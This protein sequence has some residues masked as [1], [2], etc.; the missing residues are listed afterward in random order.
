VEVAQLRA[1]LAEAAVRAQRETER[2]YDAGHSAG[3]RA[4][5]ERLEAQTQA[6]VEKLGAAVSEVAQTRAMVLR[7]AESGAVQLAVE[8]AKRIVRRELAADPSVTEGLVKAALEKLAGREIYRVRVHPAQETLLKACM[9]QAGRLQGVAVLADPTLTEGG[10]LFEAAGGALDAS[11]ETQVSEIERSL[12]DE[13][14]SR[15]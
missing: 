10:A 8:I 7:G 6:V 5:R 9:E 2:A 11:V 4:A 14:G 1:D 15:A 12:A 13:L 3:E